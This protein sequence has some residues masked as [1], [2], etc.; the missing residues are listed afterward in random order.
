MHNFVMF[1]VLIAAIMAACF[2]SIVLADDD[3]IDLDCVYRCGNDTMRQM[4]ENPPEDVRTACRWWKRLKGCLFG[5]PDVEQ[6]WHLMVLMS[7]KIS[8]LEHVCQLFDGELQH[9]RH[10]RAAPEPDAMFAGDST[11]DI[12]KAKATAKVAGRVG[13]SL[14]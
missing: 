1:S 6:Q 9:R 5:C 10:R 7:D 12:G 14:L 13:R 11:I 3:D 2:T 8:Q 4:K